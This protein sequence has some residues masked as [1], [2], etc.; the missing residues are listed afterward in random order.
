MEQIGWI[1]YRPKPFLQQKKNCITVGFRSSQAH[2][3]QVM[4]DKNSQWRAIIGE[5]RRFP[6]RLFFSSFPAEEDKLLRAHHK[7]SCRKITVPQNKFFLCF[8]LET[9]TAWDYEFYQSASYKILSYYFQIF[10]KLLYFLFRFLLGQNIFPFFFFFFVWG[11]SWFDWEISNTLRD[12]QATTALRH[13][14]KYHAN[15]ITHKNNYNVHRKE[16]SD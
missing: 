16:Q 14:N 3:V 11:K 9:T 1:W 15:Y 5:A 4:K 6:N 10:I 7:T 8:W 2:I 12:G 13:S